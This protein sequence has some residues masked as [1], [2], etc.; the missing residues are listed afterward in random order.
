[1]ETNLT[2]SQKTI[3]TMIAN[4]AAALIRAGEMTIE[5]IDWDLVREVHNARLQKLAEDHMDEILE[6]VWERANA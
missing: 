5:N 3:M 4:T 1:M 6:T 2:A